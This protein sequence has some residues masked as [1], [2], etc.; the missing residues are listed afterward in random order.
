MVPAKSVNTL[1]SFLGKMTGFRTMRRD[2]GNGIYV[3]EEVQNSKLKKSTI[4]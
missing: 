2:M 1:V 4:C 3:G